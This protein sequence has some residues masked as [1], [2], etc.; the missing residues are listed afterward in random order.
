MN[1][2]GGKLR[3]EKICAPEM[4]VMQRL[5]CKWIPLSLQMSV[6]H[7]LH[8][9]AKNKINGMTNII[10]PTLHRNQLKVKATT[11]YSDL[12]I[13]MAQRVKA[14]PMLR[15]VRD[16]SKS[17]VE[18]EAA[19]HLVV[20]KLKGDKSRCAPDFCSCRTQVPSHLKNNRSLYKQ[21]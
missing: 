9:T 15:L 3:T 19:R 12:C 5:H 8:V 7:L 16:Q 11:Q 2:K 13:I 18:S 17:A 10:L 14:I 1:L 21:A 20:I 6:H 4:C